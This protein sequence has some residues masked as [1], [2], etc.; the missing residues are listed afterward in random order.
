MGLL[1]LMIWP[2]TQPTPLAKPVAAFIA[3][4]SVVALVYPLN[5]ILQG[6]D[7]A[8]F[9]QVLIPADKYPRTGA[10]MRARATQLIAQYPRDP[11]PRF[12]RAADLLDARDLAG[13]ERE[14]RAG[15]EEEY[16]WR[17][18]LPQ[19]VGDGLR[20]FLAIAISRDR[21]QEALATARPVCLSLKDGPIRKM[22]DD[23]RLC[24][25]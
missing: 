12:T 19:Q 4:A 23:R 22:L 1:L 18:L 6:Y 25:S 15:L 8:A 21:P 14:A 16:L 5:S 3:L 9:T 11:R 7:A 2:R 17:T 24:R 13:A 20:T 10:E